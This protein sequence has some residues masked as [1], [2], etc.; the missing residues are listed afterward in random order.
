MI[1]LKEIL[2]GLREQK[3]VSM[4]KMC[5]DFKKTY[6]VTL[7]KSTISKWENGKAEPSLTYARI[8]TKYFNVTLDYLLGLEKEDLYQFNKISRQEKILLSNFNK[9]ND[10]GKN[11][12][13]TYTK[14]L[15]DNSKYCLANDEI[16]ANLEEEPSPYLIACHDD[17]LSDEEKTIMDQRIND[18]LNKR[19]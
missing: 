13:I 8:L 11:K 16:S 3:Q 6:G 14:D 9:L 18:F 12:V 4:D 7:A 2:R 1:E 5:E 15:L 17:N 19:K 10:I